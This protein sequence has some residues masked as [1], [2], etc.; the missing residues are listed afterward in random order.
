M[1][2]TT[3]IVAYKHK[4]PVRYNS[5]YFLED[6]E[7]EIIQFDSEQEAKKYIKNNYVFLRRYNIAHYKIIKVEL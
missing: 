7:M 3:Y 5:I 6:T 1:K 2:K 4:K